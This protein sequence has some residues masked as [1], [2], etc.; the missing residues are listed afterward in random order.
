MRAIILTLILTLVFGTFVNAQ[1]QSSQQ[2]AIRINTQK[3]FSKSKLTV[4]VLEIE[5]SRCPKDVECVW[6]GDAKVK[7]KVTN[8]KGKSETF[9]LHTNLEPKTVKFD[10]YEIKLGEVTPYPASNIRIDASKRT[11]QI[12]VAKM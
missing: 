9:E 4:K 3:K 11:A 5:D 8:K 12:I 7:I 6:A 2:A 1:A 10:N